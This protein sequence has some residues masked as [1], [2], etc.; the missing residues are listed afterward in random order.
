M[1][2]RLARMTTVLALGLLSGCATSSNGP[3]EGPALQ[4]PQFGQQPSTSSKVAAALTDNPLSQ[5]VSSGFHKTASWLTPEPKATA[6]L[7]PTSLA[8]ESGPPGPG[9]YVAMA[10]MHQRRGNHEAA[11]EQYEKALA[12]DPQH[13]GAILG[14][15]RWNDRQN[16]FIEATR[17]YQQAVK[18]HPRDA[19]A[20]NDLGLCYARQGKYDE[21]VAALQRAT[22]LDAE[23]P[24]YRNNLATVLAELGRTQEALKHLVAVHGQA[25]AHY[26]LGYL[27]YQ[28]GQTQAAA[29]QFTLALRENPGLHQAELWLTKLNVNPRSQ[30]AQQAA[31]YRTSSLPVR[32]V[33]LPETEKSPVQVLPVYPTTHR[34]GPQALPPAQQPASQGGYHSLQQPAL[35]PEQH[36]VQPAA[37]PPSP[38]PMTV[39][40]AS[41]K[42][43]V[44]E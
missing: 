4:G 40:P 36:Y 17:L 22:Q 28:R 43:E 35:L 27:L 38:E 11:S 12:V 13:L 39:V 30:Q 5:A 26:N 2:T 8:Y 16:N 33:S 42:L 32:A 31:P 23:R 34:P 21:A 15:A 29:E 14:Y 24:L 41:F 18:H 44:D 7:D 37:M 6:A 10:A 25:K 1:T 3:A 20:L 9:L 19:T